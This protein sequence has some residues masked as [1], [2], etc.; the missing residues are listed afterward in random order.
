MSLDV[1]LESL[2]AFHTRIV[3]CVQ[4]G[5]MFPLVSMSGEVC[6]SPMDLR[7]NMFSSSHTNLKVLEDNFFCLYL[8][9]TIHDFPS[10]SS[11][12]C[13]VVH[14]ITPNYTVE[15]FLPVNGQTN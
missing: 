15:R 13:S 1:F 10:G 5:V 3:P 6:Y 7:L 4:P 8:E 14:T 9:H 11:L 2:C 12:L